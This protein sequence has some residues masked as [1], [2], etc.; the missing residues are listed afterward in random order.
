[1]YAL[2]TI[3]FLS[4]LVLLLLVNAAPDKQSPGTDKKQAVRF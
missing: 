1:M 3:I 4:V 2:S